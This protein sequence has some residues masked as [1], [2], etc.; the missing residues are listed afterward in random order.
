MVLTC[1]VVLLPAS[2]AAQ[3]GGSLPG[4][5]YRSPSADEEQWVPFPCGTC[6]RAG[7]SLEFSQSANRRA[8][9]QGFT[10]ARV[11]NLTQREV[12]GS[13]QV[14]DAELPDSEG[15]IP[16]QVLWF[17][18]SPLGSEKGQQVVLMRYATPVSAVAFSVGQW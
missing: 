10:V 5:S 8:E 15:Y 16:S 13:I 2:A 7:I 17:V 6:E 18:L 4:A 11:R 3:N 9:A 12:A 1:G 14:L